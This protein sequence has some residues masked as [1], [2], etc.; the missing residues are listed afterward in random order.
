[1][2]YFSESPQSSPCPST[3]SHLNA[4]LKAAMEKSYW[5]GNQHNAQSSILYIL[6]GNQYVFINH[7]PWVHLWG[8]LKAK[9]QELSI[10]PYFVC[11]AYLKLLVVVNQCTIVNGWSSITYPHW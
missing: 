7:N 1:M 4:E 6:S 11:F 3:H 10:L 2:G 9:C 5:L 8:A